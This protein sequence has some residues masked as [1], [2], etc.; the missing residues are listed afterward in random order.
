MKSFETQ[1]LKVTL[2]KSYC[3]LSENHRKIFASLGLKKIGAPKVLPNTNSVLGQIN[4]VIQFVK[5]EP[6]G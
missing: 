3:G 4:K 6:Q 2:L 5:V 1:K